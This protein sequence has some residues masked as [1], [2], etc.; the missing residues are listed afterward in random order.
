MKLDYHPLVTIPEDVEV[1]DDPDGEIPFSEDSD[2]ET[3]EFQSDWSL[4]QN[5]SEKFFYLIQ[6]EKSL[7]QNQPDEHENLENEER[8]VLF[9]LLP[10]RRNKWECYSQAFLFKEMKKGVQ[11]AV[12]QEYT[13]LLFILLPFPF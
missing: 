13:R 12:D 2:Y 1:D 9:D 5:Q 11:K 10:F 7:D 6:P 3:D 8:R 4:D